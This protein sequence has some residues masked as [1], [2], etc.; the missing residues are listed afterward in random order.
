MH[1][2]RNPITL[3]ICNGIVSLLGDEI[4]K[5]NTN[6]LLLKAIC[7]NSTHALNGFLCALIILLQID[8]Q[9]AWNER[10]VL[11]LVGALVAS[12]IDL[13]HFIVARSTQLEVNAFLFFFRA[14]SY[15]SR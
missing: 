15:L 2:L 5:W 11:L 10:I 8:L 1:S 4:V 9:L 14:I 7:D 12:G 13:D 6:S 3:T